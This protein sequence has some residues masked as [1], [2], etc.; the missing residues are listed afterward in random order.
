MS[1]EQREFLVYL[2]YLLLLKKNFLTITKKKIKNW[3]KIFN[4]D[5]RKWLLSFKNSNL[6]F[7]NLI[8]FFL[9]FSIQFLI[10]CTS[11]FISKPVKN[12]NESL[13]LLAQ[14]NCYLLLLLFF[15][16]IK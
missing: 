5:T 11:L 3:L 13:V 10:F 7:K 14:V 9:L 12:E 4:T 16:L 2:N 6:H 8:V 1:K 15:K